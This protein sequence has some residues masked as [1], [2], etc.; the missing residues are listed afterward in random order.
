MWTKNLFGSRIF[1]GPTFFWT[2]ILFYNSFFR[3]QQMFKTQHFFGP[4]FF[5][6]LTF[7][8]PKFRL[9]L[10]HLNQIIFWEQTFFR[11]MF[12]PTKYLLQP[13]KILYPDWDILTW[14]KRSKVKLECGS[15]QLNLLFKL[16]SGASLIYYVFLGAV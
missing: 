3:Q 15:A 14:K 9:K 5:P 2:H 4:T 11:P 8:D 10:F 12:S 16:C 7:L 13:K 6:T 1:W